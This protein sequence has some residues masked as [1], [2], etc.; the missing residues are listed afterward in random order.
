MIMNV[1]FHVHVLIH[2]YIGAMCV[3]SRVFV[4]MCLT[5]GTCVGMS[6]SK[7]FFYL[8]VCRRESSDLYSEPPIHMYTVPSSGHEQK[9]SQT[10]QNKTKRGGGAG[11]ESPLIPDWSMATYRA[12]F[13][14]WTLRGQ[15][16][17]SYALHR[18]LCA[19]S[20]PQCGSAAS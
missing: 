14:G 16:K 13:P 4:F 1:C 8:S 7:F 20:R 19:G 5:I 17:A 18:G 10:K 9:A 15:E 6:L 12:K 3:M 11:S 2:I